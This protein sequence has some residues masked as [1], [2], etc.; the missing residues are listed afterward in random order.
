MTVMLLSHEK[1]ARRQ[2]FAE[3]GY[4]GVLLP[5]GAG[6]VALLTRGG[7]VHETT[8]AA[9]LSAVRWK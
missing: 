7:A 4:E 1:L 5:A 3:E 2:S 9:V 6:S 8:E